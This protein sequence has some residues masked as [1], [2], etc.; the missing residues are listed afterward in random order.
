MKNIGL[1]LLIIMTVTLAGF[2]VEAKTKSKG[3]KTAS[4]YLKGHKKAHQQ[5]RTV[6]SKAHKKHGKKVK[7][8]KKKKVY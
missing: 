3:Y 6:A 1:S 5:K 8:K 2:V 7:S 4:V